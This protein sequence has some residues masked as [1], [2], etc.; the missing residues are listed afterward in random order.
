MHWLEAFV[1][2]PLPTQNSPSS[3]FLSS[4]PKQKEITHSPRQY[5]VE[6]L[7]PQQQKGVEETNNLLYHNSIWKYEDDLEV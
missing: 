6:N 5:S 2:M 4:R 7:F 3:K 1:L